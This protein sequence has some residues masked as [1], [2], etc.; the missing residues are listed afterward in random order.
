M[1]SRQPPLFLKQQSAL[2]VPS[3]RMCAGGKRPRVETLYR[4]D[5]LEALGDALMVLQFAR[6]QVRC[7]GGVLGRPAR[8]GVR[9]RAMMI[10]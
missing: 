3:L 8:C 5:R 2:L 10:L 4:T 6:A 7:A 9:C 1:L